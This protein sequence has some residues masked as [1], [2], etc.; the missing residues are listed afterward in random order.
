M[1]RLGSGRVCS[2]W[3]GL[4]R[5]GPARLCSAQLGWMSDTQSEVTYMDKYDLLPVLNAML[6]THFQAA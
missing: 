3:L 1:A 4:A 6:A 2:G 5:L